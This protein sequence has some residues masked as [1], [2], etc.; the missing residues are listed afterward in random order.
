LLA[1]GAEVVGLLRRPKPDSDFFRDKLYQHVHLVRGPAD[2]VNRLRTLIAVYET[3]LVL[4]CAS[5]PDGSAETYIR[6]AVTAAGTVPVLAPVPFGMTVHPRS[7][8]NTS[9]N[10]IFARLP[11]VFGKGDTRWDRWLPRLFRAAAHGEPL[12]PPSIDSV[13][14]PVIAVRDAVDAMLNLSLKCISTPHQLG[15]RTV[16]VTPQGTAADLYAFISRL[17]TSVSRR[18]YTRAIATTPLEDSVIEAI[19]WYQRINPTK[20]LNEQSASLT[21]A[22]A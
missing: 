1:R 22:A 14:I 9:A 21:K 13:A 5:D 15:I 6:S 10:V 4:Q 16:D 19:E 3:Q 8:H 17:S 11:S 20:E 12:P 18:A 2:D 7:T